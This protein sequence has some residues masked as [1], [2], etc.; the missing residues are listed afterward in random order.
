MSSKIWTEFSK[1]SRPNS[2]NRP[3]PRPLYLCFVPE[4]VW[5]GVVAATPALERRAHV[6][7]SRGPSSPDGAAVFVPL[8]RD[9]RLHDDVNCMAAMPRAA[10]LDTRLGPSA[11]GTTSRCDGMLEDLAAK[12]EPPSEQ[13]PVNWRVVASA[14]LVV[15]LL[16][17][18]FAGTQALASHRAAA[19]RHVQ[20]SGVVIPRH[21]PASA[22]VGVPCAS[23]LAQCGKSAAALEP[24]IP[25]GSPLW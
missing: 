21:D 6:R 24:V 14:W 13:F 5:A 12:P 3:S 23:P 15:V 16:V 17:A 18:L 8:R 2:K 10:Y 4:E 20:L 25:Y 22:E 7:N 9:L 11:W 19:P 1:S